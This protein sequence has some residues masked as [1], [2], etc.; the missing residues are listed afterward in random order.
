MEWVKL[1]ATPPYYLDGAL[2]RAGEAAEVLF[3]RALAHCGNAET[4]GRVDKATVPMLTPRQPMAR[5]A[6]LV[7]EGLWSDEGTHY[8]IRSWGRLQDEHDAAALRRAQDRDRQ[9]DKRQRE[10]DKKRDAKAPV[11]QTVHV[12][13]R[14]SHTDASDVDADCHAVEEEKEKETRATPTTL[15]RQTSS[16][17]PSTALAVPSEFD[18]WWSVYPRKVGKEAARKAYAKARKIASADDLG[19]G[20]VRFRD[21]QTRDPAFTPHPSTWLN[22]G[23]WQDEGPARPLSVVPRGPRSG[24]DAVREAHAAGQR[25]LARRGLLGQPELGAS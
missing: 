1:Y 23:R 10:R 24:D 22:E 20:A 13:S 3:C 6:A 7:R 11:T 5:A 12:T 14:D 8:L 19:R 9:R 25:V 4:R 18:R 17:T 15:A 2:L 21:D 16:E